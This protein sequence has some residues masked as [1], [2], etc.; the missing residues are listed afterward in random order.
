MIDF[1]YHVVSIVAVFLALALGLFLG[2]TTLQGRVFDDL[3]GR[4]DSL[5][6]QNDQLRTQLSAAQDRIGADNAFDKALLPFAVADRLAGRFVTVVS[7]PGA[8]D[9]QRKQLITALQDA[10]ATVSA[11][12]RLQSLLVD[13]RQEQFLGSLADHLSVAGN[14]APAGA[15]GAA[16]A[17]GQLA[18]VLGEHASTHSASATLDTVLSTYAAAKVV[19]LGKTDVTRPGSLG[20]I[21]A[22]PAPSATADAAQVSAQQNVIL[23]LLRDLDSTA[24]G[25][26]LAAPTPPQGS[27]PDVIAAA[28]NAGDLTHAASTVTGVDTPA[29]LIATVFALAAQARGLAGQFGLN[30]K[31][32]PLPTASSS[33]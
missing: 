23:E 15:D 19:T 27:A 26:V 17:V 28:G 5:S 8:S 32:S 29:G 14:P 31:V 1:R 16:R 4:T 22:G 30:A 3:K 11:D 9:G 2:S 24:Q 10:G 33:P 21:L 25:A 20:V 18:A 13:P 12:V 7:A 6:K